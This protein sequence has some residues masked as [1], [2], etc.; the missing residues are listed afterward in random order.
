VTNQSAKDHLRTIVVDPE[1]RVENA[2]RV[3]D[4]KRFGAS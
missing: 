3:L 4:Y 2:V 1:K